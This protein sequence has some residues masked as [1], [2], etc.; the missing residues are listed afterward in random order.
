MEGDPCRRRQTNKNYMVD[1]FGDRQG[2][3]GWNAPD[4]LPGDNQSPSF[5]TAITAASPTGYP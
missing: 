4:Y 3:G 2:S 5:I 1:L